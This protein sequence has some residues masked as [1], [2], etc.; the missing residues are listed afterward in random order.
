MPGEIHDAA[1]EA[2]GETETSLAY[3]PEETREYV[4]GTPR[5]KQRGW[6][7]PDD[8]ADDAAHAMDHPAFDLLDD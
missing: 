8:W 3:V 4:L 5:P 2:K 6:T 1:I 7:A